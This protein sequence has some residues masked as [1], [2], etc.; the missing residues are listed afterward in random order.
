MPFESYQVRQDIEEVQYSK[1]PSFCDKPMCSAST[2]R[3]WFLTMVLES[4][5]PHT[6]AG[7]GWHLRTTDS[8]PCSWKMVCCAVLNTS[9][10]THF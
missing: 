4:Q 9:R 3:P 1:S 8:A 7:L 2:A 6:D 5:V 10:K